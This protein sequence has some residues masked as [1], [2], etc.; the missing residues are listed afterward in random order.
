MTHCTL[1]HNKQEKDNNQRMVK[2]KRKSPA[3]KPNAK[4]KRKRQALKRN[5]KAKH[6]IQAQK[7]SAKAK[8]RYFAASHI[9]MRCCYQSDYCNADCGQNLS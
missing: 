9:F 7:P 3:Q 5:A 4:A 1:R 2:A 6:K 8:A